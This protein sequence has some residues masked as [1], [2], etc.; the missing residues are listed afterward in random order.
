VSAN[1]VGNE[2]G[3][4]EIPSGEV[5]VPEILQGEA[6]VLEILHGEEIGK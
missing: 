5:K 6:R 1:L 2:T 4:I 3:K